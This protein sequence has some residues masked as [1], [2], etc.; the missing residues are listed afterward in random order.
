MPKIVFSKTLQNVNW[1]NTRLIKEDMVKEV[2]RLKQADGEGSL[3]IGGI[4]AIQT[5]MKLKMVDEF[6]LLIHPV[7]VGSGK[8][9]F[10]GVNEKL[11]FELAD[12]KTFHSGVVALH[13]L[14]SRK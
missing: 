2:I 6:W 14:A 7:I 10:D 5:F 13:Y 12:T 3:L 4:S 8:R 9:L 11:S 1:N